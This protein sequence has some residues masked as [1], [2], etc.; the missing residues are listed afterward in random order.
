MRRLRAGLVTSL[1]GGFGAPPYGHYDPCARSSL[2]GLG[3][4][5]SGTQARP[6]ACHAVCG[7]Q[8]RNRGGAPRG[9][10][11]SQGARRVSQERGSLSASRRSASPRFCEGGKRKEDEGLPGADI[12]N[13]GDDSWLFEIVGLEVAGKHAPA[14]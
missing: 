7:L 14:L 10:R 13:T 6:E 1:P 9:E 5:G 3:P 12:K 2:Y 8:W 4:V 11:T